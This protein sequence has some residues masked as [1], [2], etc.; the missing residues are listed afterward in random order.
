MSPRERI[1]GWLVSP[2]FLDAFDSKDFLNNELALPLV[3]VHFQAV[4]HH[5]PT[6]QSP[7]D[8]IELDE[9]GEE[10][11][12]ESVEEKLLQSP[13][14]P[15]PPP[16]P[17]ATT[18]SLS[19]IPSLSTLPSQ[20]L[21]KSTSWTQDSSDISTLKLP[22]QLQRQPARGRL[23][24]LG[25][26][27][28]GMMRAITQADLKAWDHWKT[29]ESRACK[30]CRTTRRHF[31]DYVLQRGGGSNF[32]RLVS[33]ALFCILTTSIKDFERIDNIKS[34]DFDVFSKKIVNDGVLETLLRCLA[35]SPL[36]L[37]RHAVMELNGLFLSKAC[38][39]I[40]RAVQQECRDRSRMPSSA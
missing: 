16:L 7:S 30:A 28:L 19:S 22:P 36:P 10:N 24:S 18:A 27:S 1:Y 39:E 13:S 17:G 2:D 25:S 14:S 12:D 8:E 34:D 38:G 3:Y 4:N 35:G 37:R 40:G 29:A 20:P 9:S 11:V 32:S 15:P 31:T 33:N 21:V 26:F 5:K 6:T 23:R